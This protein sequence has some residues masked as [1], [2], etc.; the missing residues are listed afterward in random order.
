[1]WRKGVRPIGGRLFQD[2]KRV[3]AD[4]LF[5]GNT[6]APVGG[7]GGGSQQGCERKPHLPV[8]Q[9]PGRNKEFVGPAEVGTEAPCS[10]HA[11]DHRRRSEKRYDKTQNFL[12]RLRRSLPRGLKSDLDLI[13]AKRLPRHGC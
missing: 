8:R 12:R 9:E 3:E 5:C 7:Y 1:M 2:I 13:P 4:R 6:E 10:E 11:C